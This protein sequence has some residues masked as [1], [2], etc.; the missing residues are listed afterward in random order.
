M[1]IHISCCIIFLNLCDEVDYNWFAS[2]PDFC[3]YSKL[4]YSL[5]TVRP[6]MAHDFLL[7]TCFVATI[8]R[9][10]MTSVLFVRFRTKCRTCWT[11]IVLYSY[12]FQGILGQFWWQFP[13]HTGDF[14]PKHLSMPLNS[15]PLKTGLYQI[16]SKNF[17]YQR[18]CSQVKNA[19]Y[20]IISNYKS[21]I[22]SECRIIHQKHWNKIKHC[23]MIN[24][25]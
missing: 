10:F 25:I 7:F 20:F 14:F 23:I 15:P 22:Y 13:N 5:Q 2:F 21:S 18:F 24:T 11:V 19:Q 8:F 9:H 4:I 16:W 1:H 6:A 12:K 3:R 17:H